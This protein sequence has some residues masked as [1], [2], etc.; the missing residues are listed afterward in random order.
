MVALIDPIHIDGLAQ[1]NRSLR[2]LDK[3]APKAL[4]LA[5][6]DAADL[7][8][9]WARPR[10]PARSGRARNSV[11]ARSTRTQARVIGGSA[12][13]PYYPW[14][15]FGG[16]VG[17]R[18]SIHRLFRKEGRYIYPGFTAQRDDIEVRLADSLARVIREA[19]LDVGG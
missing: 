6:N 17:P 19:G 13:V 9:A 16:R 18:K 11:K 1:L 3:D 10:V 4:R 15:D 5:H 12:R 14:L 8:V 7:V 2:Q